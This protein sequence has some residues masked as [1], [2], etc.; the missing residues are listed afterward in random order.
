MLDILKKD[1][2]S[3]L[4]IHPQEVNRLLTSQEI[5][6]IFKELGGFWKYDYE[7]GLNGK[8][9]YHALLKS[10]N[11][12][13]GF[14]NSKQVLKYPN[15]CHIM[16]GQLLRAWKRIRSP[17]P[18]KIAGIPTGATALGESL[19]YRLEL[20][21]VEMEKT[22]GKIKI[23]SGLTPGDSLLLVEDFCT[24]GT[25]FKEAVTS[26]KSKFP[27]TE[28]LPFELVIINRGGLAKIKTKH[29]VFQIVSLADHRI[30]DWSPP[31]CPLCKTYGS[32][33]LEPK[34]N[35]ENWELITTSQK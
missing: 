18:S 30:N 31:V 16:A 27:D 4:D 7:A 10:G 25:G 29:G 26:I 33:P 14:L 12:S 1:K 5:L 34:K 32:K 23:V 20:D 15:I 19:A 28:I 3:L 17:S 21:T 24:K 35:Q 8:P 2:Q 11:H 6:H 13:D 22:A 9:G